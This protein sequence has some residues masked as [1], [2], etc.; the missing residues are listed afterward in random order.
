MTSPRPLSP[1]EWEQAQSSRVLSPEEWEAK[2]AP[3]PSI[4]DQAEA[5][6]RG[7]A[8]GVAAFAPRVI[9]GLDVGVGGILEQ[10]PGQNVVSRGVRRAGQTL[11]GWGEQTTRGSEDISRV[12]GG[13]MAEKAPENFEA[14]RTGTLLPLEI[15]KYFALGPLAGIGVSALE[16]AGIKPGDSSVDMV[17]TLADR[18]GFSDTAKRLREQAQTPWGRAI[19]DMAM[20]TGLEAAFRLA[21]KGMEARRLAKVV[22]E[23]PPTE[24]P[25]AIVRY[26][27]RVTPAIPTPGPTEVG[28]ATAATESAAARARRLQTE[29]VEQARAAREAELLAQPQSQAGALQSEF[30]RGGPQAKVVPRVRPAVPLELPPPRQMPAAPSLREALEDFRSQWVPKPVEPPPP[31][32]RQGVEGGDLSPEAKLEWSRRWAEQNRQARGRQLQDEAVGGIEG[33]P[34]TPPPEA[35]PVARTPEAIQQDLD[36]LR[37][38]LV[39]QYINDPNGLRLLQSNEARLLAEL[40]QV[41]ASKVEAPVSAIPDYATP[42]DP[43]APTP[44]QG[45]VAEGRTAASERDLPPRGAQQDY[46]SFG[47]GGATPPTPPRKRRGGGGSSFGGNRPGFANP[48]LLINATSGGLGAAGGFAADKENRTR[49]TLLGLAAGLGVS[50]L[51]SQAVRSIARRPGVNRAIDDLARGLR[52]AKPEAVERVSAAGKA[53]PSSGQ[54]LEAVA[55]LLVPANRR[56][57]L[58]RLNLTPELQDKV[59]TRIAQIEQTIKRPMTDDQVRAE[60]AR[61]LNLHGN[62]LLNLDPKH[63]SGPQGLALATMVR[64]NMDRIGQLST[65]IPQELDDAARAAMV[66]ELH[67]LDG[68]T[69]QLLSTLMR[70]AT[71]QGRALAA[72]RILAN[73]TANP[74]YWMLKAQRIRGGEALTA[75]EKETIQRLLNENK[76][77]ELM[78]YLSSLRQATWYQQIVALRKA[79][80]LTGL[81]GR[82]ADFI[83]TGGNILTEGMLQAPEAMLDALV[84]NIA[85]RRAGGSA[86]SWRTTAMPSIEQTLATLKAARKGVSEAGKLMGTTAAKE[87]G[88]KGW[89]GHIRSAEIDPAALARLDVPHQTNITLLGDTKA[90]AALDTWQKFWLRFSGASDRFLRTMAYNGAL[91]EQARLTAMRE[92]LTGA[93]LTER[94]KQLVQTPTDEMVADAIAA[95]DLMTFNNEGTLARMLGSG[96]GSA[97]H[98]AG[99]WG[100]IF[101]AGMD[102]VL[103]FRRTPANVATRIAEFT[104]ILSQ[105]IAMKRGVDWWGKLGTAALEA[106][107]SGLT[108][109]TAHAAREAQRK[110]VET[111]TRG[112]VGGMGLVGLGMYLAKEGV[113][114]GAAPLT[115]AEREQWRL[116]GRQPNSLLIRGEWIPVG[117]IAPLG[118]VLAVGANLYNVG[119]KNAD[120]ETPSVLEAAKAATTT[121]GGLGG[122]L[123]T[124]PRTV[125]DQPMVTGVSNTLKALTEPEGGIG[126]T[127]ERFIRDQV[128]SFI[129]TG[130]AQLARAEGG[131]NMPQSLSDALR[132]R[133]PGMGGDIPKRLNIFGGQVGTTRGVFDTALNPLGGVP[134][135]R[136]TDPVV[137]AMNEAGVAVAPI[138]RRKGEPIATYQWRQKEA[139]QWIHDDLQALIA[140][141]EYQAATKAERAELIKDQVRRTRS[142]FSRQVKAQYG[143]DVP[144]E[145]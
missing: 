22:K 107:Q 46:G 77:D 7:T 127:T 40:E 36:Y 85:A 98:A 68:Q 34:W 66:E 80:L 2:N 11:R 109:E 30:R 87:D 95:S 135:V 56:P 126:Q 64:E 35:P 16:N 142:A 81:K 88:L 117:R 138:M 49:G 71:E 136:A 141:P 45:P 43:N 23:A 61:L 38:E 24:Q 14:G 106:S 113:M 4:F 92:G 124:V 91:V 44:Y 129:P 128:G 29:A 123:F 82:A 17:A 32:V 9:A 125:L 120:T 79:G 78:K 76:K 99:P 84:S 90:N 102:W 21:M 13:K 31:V 42:V 114:T 25:K 89:V 118:S 101:R 104:P 74:T 59:A 8:A 75:P 83:S 134:D 96:I 97:T 12:I 112:G 86:V 143:V 73:L 52:N 1:E 20:N 5:Q 54:P 18:A 119:A 62:D 139:G 26:G 27:E 108:K 6:L 50:Q 130:I 41:K 72:N 28:P 69:N 15:S 122:T 53:M 37:N 132:A 115:T 58:Q 3:K 63:M 137:R 145:P 93:K 39:P 19:G 100:R 10:T 121:S 33:E 111:L 133:I 51:G 67:T 110:M 55:D 105:A 131:Q 65:R 94:A 48:A 140:L 57:L 60:A 103:P 70:G 116:E 144:T 47:S